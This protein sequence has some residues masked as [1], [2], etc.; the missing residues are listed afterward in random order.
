M[1]LTVKFYSV[2][3]AVNSTALPTGEPM[4]EY[5]C[6]MLD[7]C[8]ILR[9]VIL[10]NVGPQANP[11]GAN[12]A[13]I[14]E[15]NRYYWVSDWTVN[16]GQ[17]AATLT[18]DPLASWKTEIGDTYQ[19]VLRS[20]SASNPTVQ[21]SMYP[22]TSAS[23]W[24]SAVAAENPFAHELGS[25]EYV[26]GVVG[27][28]GTMGAV[29][30]YIMTPAQ[31]D[32]F[33]KK[34]YGDTSIYG[35][36][37]SEISAF[38]TQFNPLQYI[39]YC[40]W[41]PFTISKGVAQQY[42]DFGWW[43][44]ETPCYKIPANPIYIVNTEFALPN[45]PQLSRGTYLN[46]SPFSRYDLIYGTFGKVPLDASG[47]PDTSDRT[48][49]ANMQVDLITG[50]AILTVTSPGG[51]SLAYASGKIGVDISLAQIAVD[52]K[53]AAVQ[54][55]QTVGAAIASSGA[56][57]LTGGVSGI[58]NA[59]DSLIPQM[60]TS[61]SNGSIADYYIIP[62]IV[63]Q[64]ITIAAED[65]DRLGRPLCA[66]RKINTLSGYLQ[67]VDTELQIPATSGEIDMIKSYMEGGMHFD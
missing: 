6:R 32:A 57:L 1:A 3:K 4:A 44:L 54:A 12:Y 66:R 38:K 61:G 26:L 49:N 19:Y 42:I 22:A 5:E 55:I 59:I 43:Q 62:R 8:S 11:T 10:L 31:F 21:D 39:V 56:S 30:Y 51:G 46:K 2:S 9:P 63:C 35:V 15:Y 20:A 13:Y 65:N 58:S 37:E 25:G 28:S 16:R 14:S 48:V 50:Y 41:F 45:H 7:A 34:L 29:S 33:G 64:F 27:R 53:G 18:I 24:G 67:T 52:Y 36:T 60:R 23:T 17:W 40:Q 47:L